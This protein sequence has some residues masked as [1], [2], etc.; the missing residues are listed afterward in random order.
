MRLPRIVAILI[1]ASACSDA[2]AAGLGASFDSFRDIHRDTAYGSLFFNETAIRHSENLVK[3]RFRAV[4]GNGELDLPA[5]Q[6]YCFV[7]NHYG[8][9]TVDGK[10]RTYRA[11]ISKIL[12]D[13]RT[14]TE[15]VEQSFYPTDDLESSNVPDLCVA[16]VRNA[17]KVA[18]DFTSDD[19]DYFDWHI[20]FTPK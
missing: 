1:S 11:K 3:K 12:T 9:P 6:G 18:I 20:S 13:G 17:S 5:Q 2:L 15:L 7:L 4:S 8:R 10:V 14:T 16:G 19:Q